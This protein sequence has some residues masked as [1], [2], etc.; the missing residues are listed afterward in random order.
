ME[1]AH[2]LERAKRAQEQAH[3]LLAVHERSPSRV[4]LL[5]DLSKSLAGAP[6][7]VQD[8]FREAISCLENGLFWAAIVTSWAGHFHM[9]SETLYHSHEVNIRAC[10]P[11]WRFG[12][13]AELKEQYPEA[14]ILDV[15]KEV[16]FVGKA[17]LKVLHGQLSQRNQC[18]HPTLYKPSMNVAIGYVDEQI[19]QALLY[20][21]LG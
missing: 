8:Y 2:W 13:L 6:V 20:I 14:Q 16:K 18:A 21:E 10:R 3:Q 4:I 15:G 12:D 5:A 7:D 9:F 19:R 11:K 1:I 17:Q